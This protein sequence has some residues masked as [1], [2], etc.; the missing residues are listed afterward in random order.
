M[1]FSKVNKEENLLDYN[2]ELILNIL[3][4]K[5]TLRNSLTL[6]PTISLNSSSKHFLEIMKKSKTPLKFSKPTQSTNH[7]FLHLPISLSTQLNSGI[8]KWLLYF[9]KETSSTCTEISLLKNKNSSETFFYLNTSSKLTFSSK[10]VLPLSSVFFFQ[11]LK[12]RIGLSSKL[13][14]MKPSDQLLNLLLP[15]SF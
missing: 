12:L 11:L 2:I 6:Q 7:R 4:C 14:S 13:F 3:Q 8:D 10:R 9:L 5:S 15:L 1:K